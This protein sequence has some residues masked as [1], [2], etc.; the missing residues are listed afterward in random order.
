MVGACRGQVNLP[1][2]SF[3][4]PPPE[5]QQKHPPAPPTISGPRP[6]VM[7]PLPRSWAT[8]QSA[9]TTLFAERRMWADRSL[10][11]VKTSTPPPRLRG[12]K[13][14]IGLRFAFSYRR[15][16]LGESEPRT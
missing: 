16:A 1:Q 4:P 15:S 7:R 3:D 5:V 6:L 10:E 9:G 14:G 8:P 13:L 11:P 12:G 2:C